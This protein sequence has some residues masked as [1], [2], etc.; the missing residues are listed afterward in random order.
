MQKTLLTCPC[1]C[2]WKVAS[3]TGCLE[4][5]SILS[6][7]CTECGCFAVNHRIPIETVSVIVDQS[8]VTSPYSHISSAAGTMLALCHTGRD[9]DSPVYHHVIN[10]SNIVLKIGPESTQCELLDASFAPNMHVVTV[11]AS[12]HTALCGQIL[13]QT[14]AQW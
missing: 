6:G 14:L 12:K 4:W 3:E 2:T 5:C 11:H 7:A 13:M 9:W 8:M 10:S 1:E